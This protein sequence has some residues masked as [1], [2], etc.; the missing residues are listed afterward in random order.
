MTERPDCMASS[1]LVWP[2]PAQWLQD[3]ER[4]LFS[5]DTPPTSGPPSC[6]GCPTILR[7]CAK[8]ISLQELDHCSSAVIVVRGDDLVTWFGHRQASHVASFAALQAD[9]QA[10]TWKMEK[11]PTCRKQEIN[12]E[13]PHR[14]LGALPNESNPPST[15]PTRCFLQGDSMLGRNPPHCRRPDPLTLSCP[16]RL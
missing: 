7:N 15:M 9:A 13:K 14:A 2:L 16:T 1:H 5:W 8:M 11:L 3:G 6:R 12:K 4:G 10:E